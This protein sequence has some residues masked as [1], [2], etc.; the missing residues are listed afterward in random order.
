MCSIGAYQLH[1]FLCLVRRGEDTEGEALAEAVGHRHHPQ[2]VDNT[3]LLQHGH[4]RVL[5]R[6]SQ[7]A[8][9]KYLHRQW[10]E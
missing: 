10:H 9:D 8:A 3:A 2:V 5:G 4:Q 7:Q 1:G 6:L